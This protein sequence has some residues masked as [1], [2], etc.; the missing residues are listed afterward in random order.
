[1][2]ADRFRV[3]SLVARVFVAG[4]LLAGVLVPGGVSAQSSGGGDGS[5][6]ALRVWSDEAG[7]LRVAWGVPDPVPSDYRVMWAPEGEGF[8]S[9]SDLSGNAYPESASLV[10][11]G[12]DADVDYRVQ[13]RARYYDGQGVRLWSGPWSD[14]VA[15]GASG[16]DV[17]GTVLAGTM[18]WGSGESGGSEFVGY[19]RPV[20]SGGPD[21]VG[22]FAMRFWDDVV[23]RSRS[24]LFA[25]AQ[26][27]GPVAVGPAGGLENPVI[28]TMTI[29]VDLVSGF[30]LEVGEVLYDSAEAVNPQ[31]DVGAFR[32]WMWDLPDDLWQADEQ[33]EFRII[34]IDAGDSAP[35]AQGDSSLVSLSIDGATLDGGFDPGVMSYTAVGQSG[36]AQITVGAVS[37]DPDARSVRIAPPDVDPDVGGH[38][39]DLNSDGAPTVVTVTVVAADDLTTSAYDVTVTPAETPD[40]RAAEPTGLRATVGGGA[41]HLSWDPSPAVA[42]LRGD[43]P[44]VYSIW[45]DRLDEPAGDSGGEPTYDDIAEASFSDRDVIAGGTYRY[46]VSVRNTGYANASLAGQPVTVEVPAP[47]GDAAPQ[48]ARFS[49]GDSDPI[50]MQS[51]GRRHDVAL[52]S[53]GGHTTVSLQ[54]N[55]ID[56]ALAAQTIRADQFTLRDQDLAQPVDLSERGDTL[57]IVRAQSPDGTQEQAY[58]IRLQPP[59]T[60]TGG[61][62][63][64]VAKSADRSRSAPALGARSSE[65][66]APSLSALTLSAGTLDPAFAATTRDYTAAVSHDVTQITVTPTAAPGTTVLVAAPDNDTD[67]AGHQVA[68]NASTQDKPAQTA[69]VIAVSNSAGRLD[70][71]TVTVTRAAASTSDDET[72]SEPLSNDA[73]LAGLSLSDGELTPDFDTATNTYSTT[74]PAS[75]GWVTVSAAATFAGAVVETSPSDANS[76]LAGHQVDLAASPNGTDNG[77]TNITVTVTAQDTITTATYNITVTRPPATTFRSTG[78]DVINAGRCGVKLIRGLWSDSQT[79]WVSN[80]N[81]QDPPSDVHTIDIATGSCMNSLGLPDVHVTFYGQYSWRTDVIPSDVWSDGESMWVLDRWGSLSKHDI[82]NHEPGAFAIGPGEQVIDSVGYH[83][84]AGRHSYSFGMWSDGDI[85]WIVNSGLET[86]KVRSFELDTGTR[87]HD[88]DLPIQAPV[89]Y[90]NAWGIVDKGDIWSDGSTAWVIHQR[91]HTGRA[92]DLSNG[93][94]L[95]HLDIDFSRWDSRISR[96][97]GLWSDGGTMWVGNSARYPS[98]DLVLGFYLPTVAALDSLSVGDADIGFSPWDTSYTAT[99]ADTADTVT[100]EAAAQHDDASVVI[101]PADA[102]DI[103]DG[104]QVSL[105]PGENTITVTS[106]TYNHTMTY[107]VTVTVP[108]SGMGRDAQEVTQEPEEVTQESEEVDSEQIPSLTAAFDSASRSSA[109]I[110]V[111]RLAFSEPLGDGFSYRILRDHSFDDV[112]GVVTYVRRVPD[113]DGIRGNQHWEI[114]VTPDAGAAQTTVTLRAHADCDADHALCTGDDRPLANSPEVIITGP[115][116]QS[117]T[118]TIDNDLDD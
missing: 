56:A 113:A 90:N 62:G 51:A 106:G 26:I 12:L 112:G 67:T 10:L 58:T 94:R 104:H 28:L 39:I 83:A 73:S 30:V 47:L 14:V 4:V 55:A 74:V 79:L 5:V 71:Y 72:R 19:S 22:A 87:L 66:A 59:P 45:R 82:L 2:S 118:F 27:R 117:E 70:S 75:T 63:Q 100:V 49:V 23:V 111:L 40:E 6:S 57:V 25:L 1:M 85:I 41:V 105:S 99:V 109:G 44:V 65:P 16:G 80:S 29:G 77:T 7:V 96:P 115:N 103:A 21:R 114:H 15:G 92:F 31:G 60:T 107:T 20:Y 101:L 3:L 76:L 97:S 91:E 35:T 34:A 8:K 17:A 33:A 24:Q 18:R 52:D 32:Y 81:L 36:V 88:R 48:L 54:A 53:A 98:P 108:A 37:S 102:D 84:A 110:F 93:D 89:G 9:W 43:A 61:G 46:G 116:G 69:V 50:D 11:E 38:Q 95:E 13:V 68:L 86:T 64:N 78:V 42:P